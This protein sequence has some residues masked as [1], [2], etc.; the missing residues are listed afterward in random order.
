MA[1]VGRVVNW[2]SKHGIGLIRADMSDETLFFHVRDMDLGAQP[3]YISERVAFDAER[4]MNGCAL[5][6]HIVPVR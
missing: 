4:D 5:A 3:P 6:L 2:D 1:M